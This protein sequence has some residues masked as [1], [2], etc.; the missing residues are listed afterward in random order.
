M[1]RSWRTLTYTMTTSAARSTLGFRIPARSLSRVAFRL[2]VSRLPHIPYGDSHTEHGNEEIRVGRPFFLSIN[3]KDERKRN[4]CMCVCSGG[5]LCAFARVCERVC[6]CACVQACACAFVYVRAFACVCLRLRVRL[7]AHARVRARV[8][9]CVCARARVWFGVFARVCACVRG[10]SLAP[11]AHA[12]CCFFG[13]FF[14]L[15]LCFSCL[16][17]PRSVCFTCCRL[18]MLCVTRY[19]PPAPPPPPPPPQPRFNSATSYLLPTPPLLRLYQ[20]SIKALP[21]LE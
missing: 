5:C 3:S 15:R 11:V 9:V 12:F 16:F 20:G 13:G 6:V 1:G 7:R 10:S 14:F 8:C 4:T 18:A 17:V 19:L 21:R 2:S